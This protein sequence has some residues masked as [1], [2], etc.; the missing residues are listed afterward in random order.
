MLTRRSFL[1]TVAA[2]VVVLLLLWC[3]Q[4]LL[5]AF[6]IAEPIATVVYVLIVLVAVLYLVRRF[7]VL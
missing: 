3:V 2:L 4:R 7:G 5:A 6:A 1:G